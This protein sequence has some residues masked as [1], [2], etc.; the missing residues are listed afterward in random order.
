MLER[1]FEYIRKIDG[2]KFP[3]QLTFI[4]SGDGEYTDIV[5]RFTGRWHS[6]FPIKGQRVVQR[7]KTGKNDEASDSDFQRYR[8]SKINEEKT[9]YLISTVYYKT[10]IY[11]NLSI[12]RQPEGNQKPGFCDFPIDYTEKYF[13]QLTAEEMMSDGSFDD[14]GRPHETLDCRVYSLCA[15]DVWLDNE[16]KLYREWAKENSWRRAEIE[17]ITH[18][19]VIDNLIQNTARKE[20]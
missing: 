12:R 5:Y 18:R 8:H 9:I 3:I 19:N 4:D 17:A 2:F 10:Q 13:K 14:K 16:L 7:K 20:K 6:T 11:N 1:N 15:A